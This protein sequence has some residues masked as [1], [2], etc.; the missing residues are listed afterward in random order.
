MKTTLRRIK[1]HDPCSEG[2]AKLLKH[3]N[4]TE[5]DDEELSLLTILESNGREDT[6]WALRCVDGYDREFRLY[7]VW[8][9]RQVQ[10]LMTDPRSTD[11]VDVAERY[12]NGEAT[13]GADR[14]S[15]V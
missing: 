9:A 8:C 14:K 1:E 11:A 2:W 5:A 15:V 4:K 6:I 12:A 13:E 3:L 10:H 7:A